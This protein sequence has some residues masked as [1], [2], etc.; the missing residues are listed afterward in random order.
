MGEAHKLGVD[1]VY[2]GHEFDNKTWQMLY[3]EIDILYSNSSRI[4]YL[5]YLII[6]WVKL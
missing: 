2:F 3:H 1:V 5:T 4:T 6:T